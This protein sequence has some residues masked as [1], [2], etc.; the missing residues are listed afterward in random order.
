M[1]SA[2]ASILLHGPPGTGKVNII[3]KPFIVEFLIFIGR[4]NSFS[5]S[6]S[7]RGTSSIYFGWS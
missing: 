2:P 5:T 1:R 3:D 6:S 7:R 4:E